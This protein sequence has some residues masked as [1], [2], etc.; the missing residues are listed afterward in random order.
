MKDKAL[1][2]DRGLTNIL[3]EKL[4]T[5]EFISLCRYPNDEVIGRAL[6]FAVIA[7]LS[8]V[9]DRVKIRRKEAFA[10]AGLG[11]REHR[12]Q[13]QAQVWAYDLVLED[14]K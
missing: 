7:Q 13:A 1:L 4:T 8:K 5:D 3:Q 9:T 11:S 12:L 14:L 2:T 6:T 10:Q